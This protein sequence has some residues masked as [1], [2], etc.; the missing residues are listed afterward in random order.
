L[1]DLKLKTPSKYKKTI[2]TEKNVAH[3]R[4]TH[5]EDDEL[6]ST[7]I[8]YNLEG[9]VMLLKPES[10]VEIPLHNIFFTTSWTNGL[11]IFGDYLCYLTSRNSSIVY[12]LEES[13]D[14]IPESFKFKNIPINN[15]IFKV[16]CSEAGVFFVIGKE[17]EWIAYNIDEDTPFNTSTIEI[18]DARFQQIKGVELSIDCHYLALS[19]WNTLKDSVELSIYENQSQSL[20]STPTLLVK[21]DNSMIITPMNWMSS[22][23]AIDFRGVLKGNPILAVQQFDGAK[24]M[25]LL[26][27]DL[28]T[29]ELVLIHRAISTL[30]RCVSICGNSR[31][32]F[33]ASGISRNL[34]IYNVQV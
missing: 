28:E 34:G 20:Y 33:V 12:K 3:C 14:E 25:L 10:N 15:H 24:E 16:G 30:D 19:T 1:Y 4:A 22:F 11:T 27:I 29:R 17:F 31:G 6:Y 21:M 13:R 26:T 7:I 18:N 9:D 23:I 32:W 5:K 2:P 8:Y